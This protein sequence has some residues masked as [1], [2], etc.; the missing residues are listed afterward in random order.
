MLVLMNGKIDNRFFGVPDGAPFCGRKLVFGS[1]FEVLEFKAVFLLNVRIFLMINFFEKHFVWA[2]PEA[3]VA[4]KGAINYHFFFGFGGVG[5]VFEYVEIAFEVAIDAVEFE[6][7][8][9]VVNHTNNYITNVQF[10]TD[11]CLLF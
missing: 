10:R 8:V 4:V 2:T 9:R 7:G 6:A 1:G 11:A 3:A 5:D